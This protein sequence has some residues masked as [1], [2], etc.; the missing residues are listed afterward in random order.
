M[1]G[2]LF[3]ITLFIYTWFIE[4]IKNIIFINAVVY[5]ILITGQNPEQW[6]VLEVNTCM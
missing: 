6:Q 3:I 2:I 1:E 4:L 5:F